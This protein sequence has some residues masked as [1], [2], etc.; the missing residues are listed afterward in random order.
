MVHATVATL[1]SL[2][3]SPILNAEFCNLFFDFS[4]VLTICRLHSKFVTGYNIVLYMEQNSAHFYSVLS[5]KFTNVNDLLLFQ[6]CQGS[7]KIGASSAY[8]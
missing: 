1:H 4:V 3:Y 2:G 8:H 6:N 7:C 5:Q